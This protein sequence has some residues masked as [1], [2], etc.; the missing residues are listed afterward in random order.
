MA[1]ELRVNYIKNR[2]GLGTVT[3]TDNGLVISGI[4]S[5]DLGSTNL[6]VGGNARVSGI[7]TATSFSGSGANLTGIQGFNEL[8]AALFS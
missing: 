1:S 3:F 7:V 4:T 2:S 5:L 6:V 8:D